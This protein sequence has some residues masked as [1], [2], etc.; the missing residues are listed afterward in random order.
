VQQAPAFTG[1]S[2]ARSA[3]ASR[4]A[5]L[6]REEEI[7]QVLRDRR[8]DEVADERRLRDHISR[9]CPNPWIT[10]SSARNGAG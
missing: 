7:D 8:G 1:D 2:A 9:L 6:A 10:E 4:V 3:P 5:L